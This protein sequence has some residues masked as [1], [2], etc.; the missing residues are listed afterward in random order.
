MERPDLEQRHASNNVSECRFTESSGWKVLR[1]FET[2]LHFP[3]FPDE[4][5]G[6]ESRRVALVAGCRSTSRVT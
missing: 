5:H 4:I 2:C 6:A 1:D 3:S